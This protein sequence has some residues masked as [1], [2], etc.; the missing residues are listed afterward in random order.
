MGSL[1]VYGEAATV[2]DFLTSQETAAHLDAVARYARLLPIFRAR[3]AAVVD[4]ERVEPREFWR[5][6]RRE[7]FAES[8]YDPNPLIDALFDTDRFASDPDEVESHV[9]ALAGLI[10]RTDD[11]P[12]IAAAA[13]M[14]ATSLGYSP[15]EVM[16]DDHMRPSE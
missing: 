16:P 7:A 14:L 9:H 6:A 3:I 15:N 2:N 4:F 13:V 5:C 1:G 8:G 10:E 12:A 11:A